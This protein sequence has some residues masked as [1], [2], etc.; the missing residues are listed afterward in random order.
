MTKLEQCKKEFYELLCELYGEYGAEHEFPKEELFDN[1]WSIDL[2]VG[3]LKVYYIGIRNEN[4]AFEL[5]MAETDEERAEIQK[6]HDLIT[7]FVEKWE[8]V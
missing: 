5:A 3:Y 4:F 2:L 6:S 8:L 7:D 1:N